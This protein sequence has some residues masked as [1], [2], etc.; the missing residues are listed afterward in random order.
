MMTEEQ[1]NMFFAFY[2]KILLLLV[3]FVRPTYWQTGN[4]LP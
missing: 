3:S 2:T 1:N 4:K